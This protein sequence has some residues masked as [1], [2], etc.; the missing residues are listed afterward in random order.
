MEPMGFEN[1]GS[2]LSEGLSD[3]AS[4]YVCLGLG[5]ESRNVATFAAW[6][7]WERRGVK[8]IQFDGTGV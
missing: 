7:S 5:A 4:A 8:P 1:K 6:R 2:S 3:V